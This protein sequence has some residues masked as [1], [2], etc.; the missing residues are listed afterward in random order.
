ML[1]LCLFCIG[2]V[3]VVDQGVKIYARKHWKGK[4][5]K[6]KFYTLSFVKN[7][8][9]FR[10]LLKRKPRVLKGIHIT[11]CLF[12]L[13]LWM[14]SLFLKKNRKLSLGLAFLLAGGVG[15]LYDR[16]KHGYVTDFIALK[17][18]GNLY[19]N[20]ADFSVFFGAIWSLFHS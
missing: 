12:I 4:S 14:A 7:E 17:P 6:R 18:S 3:F 5:I 11:A 15:N 13:I 9:A 10:G 16:L 8:G 20:V 2:I 19:Y 1:S